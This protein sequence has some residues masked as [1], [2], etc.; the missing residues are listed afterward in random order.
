MASWWEKTLAALS[1]V[2]SG[3]YALLMRRPLPQLQGKLQVQ[4]LHEPVEVI[5]DRYGIPHIYAG[6]ED[7]LFFAQGYVHARER[8]WQMEFNRRLGSGRLSELFGDVTLEV[9]RF[10]RRLG[11]HRAAI[12]G[13]ERL[14]EQSKHI[15][16]AYANGVNTYIE[17]NRRALPIEFRLLRFKPAPW[18]TSDS[19]QWA[20]MMGWGESSNWE[21]EIIRSRIVANIGAE[22]AARLEVGY[23]PGHPLIIPPGVEYQGINL[24]MLEQYEAI[25]QMSG[26]GMMGA[27]NSW[28]V[29]GSMTATDSPI[30]CND[31]HLGQAAP[32]IWY[33]CHLVTGDMNITGASFPGTPG[34]VIGHNEQVAWALTNAISDVEDLYIEKFH[35]QNPHQYEFQG[36]W[37]MHR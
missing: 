27:S 19:L 15:L 5:T 20:K 21:T 22:R 2:A 6:N 25:K 17:R 1:G 11:M 29:D 4:G 24:G 36:Q 18:Q 9:D 31:P 34:I 7:D 28:V 13:V 10:C 3:G 33:E 32:S 30:L 16:M 37:E 35:P 26:L 14:A 12:D 8:L 23:D